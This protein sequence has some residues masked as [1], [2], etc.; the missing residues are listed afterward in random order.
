MKTLDLTPGTRVHVPGTR[1]L[2]R[3]VDSVAPHPSWDGLCVVNW[4]ERDERWSTANLASP[5]KTWRVA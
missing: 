2:V 5:A 4:R 3:T 1:S